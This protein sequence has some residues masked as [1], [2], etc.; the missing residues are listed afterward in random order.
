MDRSRRPG[1][2]E[3]VR[4]IVFQCDAD[5]L[6][7]GLIVRP[8][9]Q[10]SRRLRHRGRIGSQPG[11]PLANHVGIRVQVACPDGRVRT[12]VVEQLT[13]TARQHFVNGLSW[14]PWKEFKARQA[15]GWDVTVPVTAFEGVEAA[16][17]PA[18]MK[19]LNH[20]VGQPFFGEICTAFVE[21]VF[22]GGRLFQDVEILD[23]LV[24]GSG[25]RIPEPAAPIF[26]PGARL[27]R[28]VRQLLRVDELAAVHGDVER[29]RVAEGSGR[30]ADAM[31]ASEDA[32]G[33][34][35]AS[36]PTLGM[37]WFWVA[38]QVGRLWSK[39]R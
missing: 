1:R 39:Q 20:E 11:V 4:G 27:S 29:A 10:L 9:Q 26:K 19:R 35:D 12:Y 21:R 37:V 36:R 24:P 22:G 38:A 7:S 33:R 30:T 3:L 8:M 32:V 17:V 34:L 16:D 31:L 25:P 23:R 15:G 13:G 5:D 14:T 18:A 2:V 6:V 28:R